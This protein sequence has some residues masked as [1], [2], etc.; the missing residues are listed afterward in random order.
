[1]LSLIRCILG[2]KDEILSLTKCKKKHKRI[3]IVLII[4]DRLFKMYSLY[5][6][7]P[8]KGSNETTNIYIFY[9]YILEFTLDGQIKSLLSEKWDG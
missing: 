9:G 6:H 8:N 2:I 4:R 3:L 1:M 5:L 7:F